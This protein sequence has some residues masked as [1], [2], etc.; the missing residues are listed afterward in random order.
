VVIRGA[1]ERAFCAGAYLDDVLP[2]IKERTQLIEMVRMF[3]RGIGAI[4][5]CGK[6]TVAAIHGFCTAGGFEIMCNCDFAVATEDAKIGDFHMQKCLMA[7][8]GPTPLLVRIVGARKAKEILM[9]GRLMSGKEAY[10]LGLLN[11]LAPKGK[12][13]ET[14]AEFLPLFTERAIVGLTHVKFAIESSLDADITTACALESLAC[15]SLLS[16]KTSQE[17]VD[18]FLNKRKPEWP[19]EVDWA[20]RHG[21]Y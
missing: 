9:S 10:E 5:N 13:D 3:A 8:A 18:A 2:I 21:N 19:E 6:P 11:R 4:R 12:L 17:G 15:A 16:S 7:G 20:L 14:L 1:G